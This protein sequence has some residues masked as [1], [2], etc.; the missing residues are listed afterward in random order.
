MGQQPP[1]GD[2]PWPISVRPALA[3]GSQADPGRAS[4]MVKVELG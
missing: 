4:T 2:W 3:E 1:M